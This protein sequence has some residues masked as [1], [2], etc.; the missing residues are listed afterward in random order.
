MW[1]TRRRQYQSVMQN[2][3]NISTLHPKC[4]HTSEQPRWDCIII[5]TDMEGI[6][7]TNGI[8]SGLTSGGLHE[9]TNAVS[10]ESRDVCECGTYIEIYIYIYI[11]IYM[12]M[13]PFFHWK[14]CMTQQLPRSSFLLTFNQSDPV[15]ATV[16]IKRML[17]WPGAQPSS[18]WWHRCFPRQ[19]KNRG[20][21][22]LVF[23]C[24]I[25]MHPNKCNTRILRTCH[26]IL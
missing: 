19:R 16:V 7:H 9:A 3:A 1:A 10:Y 5:G 18:L 6:R 24:G 25:L 14:D 21:Q 12:Y 15:N 8:Q 11:Y 2:H 22:M 17:N 4:G 26:I 20:E 23:W 13:F